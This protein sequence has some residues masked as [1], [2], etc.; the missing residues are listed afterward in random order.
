MA[1]SLNFEAAKRSM[2]NPKKLQKERDE[3]VEWINQVLNSH[4]APT[5]D[6][7]DLTLQHKLNID[8]LRLHG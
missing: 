5:I 7:L 8:R 4:Q 2:L 6:E 1:V 3:Y